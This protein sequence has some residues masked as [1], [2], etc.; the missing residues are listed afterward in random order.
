MSC[1]RALAQDNDEQPGGEGLL[2]TARRGPAAR[3]LLSSPTPS[4]V[5]GILVC[6]KRATSEGRGGGKC[7][8]TCSTPEQSPVL[9]L[10]FCQ[11]GLLSRLKEPYFSFP[12]FNNRQAR[13]ASRNAPP[14]VD[15]IPSQ[16][17]E[18]KGGRALLAWLPW[19]PREKSKNKR[20]PAASCNDESIAMARERAGRARCGAPM[21]GL[22]R[23][24]VEGGS[25]GCDAYGRGEP[26]REGDPALP[27]A[28]H[29]DM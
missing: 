9:I 5:A 28:S 20:E 22:E 12:L 23:I 2:L 25:G 27:H 8:L 17:L 18:E 4:L 16:E 15:R 7:I 24:N 21:V 19:S 10:R 6:I 13:R 29:P 1:C 11:F 26:A 14:Q 3:I